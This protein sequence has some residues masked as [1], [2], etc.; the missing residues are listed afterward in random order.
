MLF[1]QESL[2]G[3]HAPPGLRRHLRAAEGCLKLLLPEAGSKVKGKLRTREE[4]QQASGYADR[5]DDF[6]ELLEILDRELRLVTAS[7]PEDPTG[8]SANLEFAPDHDLLYRLTHDYLVHSV[9][10]WLEQNRLDRV[11]HWQGRAEL[12]LEELSDQWQ[13]ARDRRFLPGP[14]EFLLIL[15][16]FPWKR[17]QPQQRR[18]MR[19]ASG[20]YGCLAA[21]AILLLAGVGVGTRAVGRLIRDSASQVN[22]AQIQ[23]E[24]KGIVRQLIDSPDV[25]GPAEFIEILEHHRTSHGS[26][27]L[28]E[29]ASAIHQ[30]PGENDREATRIRL[31]ERRAD[32]PTGNANSLYGGL[33][34]TYPVISG[35]GH[36]TGGFTRLVASTSR[37][38]RSL[39]V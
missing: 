30:Q 37:D 39:V 3:P 28:P 15:L 34:M 12:R 32:A 13:I 14:I 8:D 1:L 23:A 21:V 10:Q 6:S 9:R 27:L 22:L 18:L 24:S 26:W 29:L 38:N 7:R 4:L 31:G 11:K 35:E 20:W 2:S 36:Q 16:A 25:T 33:N 5:P 17:Y 19:A